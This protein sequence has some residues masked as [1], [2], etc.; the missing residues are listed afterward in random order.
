MSLKIYNSIT[1]RKED[2]KPINA[3]EV[4]M[5]VCGPTVYGPTHVGHARSYV[6]FDVVYRYLQFLGFKV[7]YVQN[8][9][10][11]GHLVGDGD[12]G[13]DKIAKQAKKEHIDPYEIAYKYECLYF[14]TMRELNVLRPSISV[15]A[16]ACIPDM[17]KMVQAIIDKGYGYVTKKGN[18]YFD[19]R[20]FASY[21]SLSNRTLDKTKSGERIEVASDKRN[22]EDFALWKKAENGHIM[23]WDSPWG[24]GYPGWHLECSTMSKKFLGETFDIHGG[25]LDNI[26]PHH[27][28]EIAQSEVANGK[29]FV[30]YFMHNN[31]ITVNGTKMGKSLNNFITLEDLFKQV[32]PMWVRY[33][34]LL[35]HYR[36]PIDFTIEA[37]K[38]AGEQFEKLNQMV[39]D[40][41]LV[42]TKKAEVKTPE[43]KNICE[44]FTAAMNEDFNTP[45]A[46]S[47]LIKLP[48]IAKNALENQ[49]LQQICEINTII[50]DFME[51]ILGL[52]FAEIKA[53]DNNNVEEL[54]KVIDEVRGALRAQ[55]NYELSDKIRDRVASLGIN[56]KDKKI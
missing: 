32:P 1:K 21:G 19:V 40:L 42:T 24:E 55:K 52:E 28:S 23:K 53:Q 12:D 16:T 15:R 18:V 22:P 14:D 33:F 48:K 51:R 8:I 31:L 25:G 27:E 11:V 5:Y 49:N 13:E 29:P 6:D 38:K 44:N 4:K 54:L 34:I 17:I 10:D 47:E 20:K 2:F 35:F 50:C 9:T 7:K 41:R 3:G 46:I 45:V 26:F 56:L 39:N 43:L 36:S 37:I 30:N